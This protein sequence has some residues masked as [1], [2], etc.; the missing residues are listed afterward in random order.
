MRQVFFFRKVPSLSPQSFHWRHAATV[1]APAAPH[2]RPPCLPLL[3]KEAPL[4]L[5]P[6]PSLPCSFPRGNPNPSPEMSSCPPPLPSRPPAT[7]ATPEQTDTAASSADLSYAS[8]STRACWDAAGRANRARFSGSARRRPSALAVDSGL[9]GHHR[10]LHPLRGEL[11]TRMGLL[12]LPL[13]LS[14]PW[15]PCTPAELRRG[16]GRRHTSG[17]HLVS[18]SAPLGSPLPPLSPRTRART[19]FPQILSNSCSTIRSSSVMSLM[20][21]SPLFFLFS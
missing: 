19:N 8:P 18:P 16:H 6:P 17:D 15:S 12:P 5:A 3:D 7:P 1:L 4:R 21:S 13:P 2:C 9:P 14:E 11:L 20:T 10:P